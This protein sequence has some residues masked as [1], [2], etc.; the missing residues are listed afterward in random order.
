[1]PMY[2]YDCHDCNIRYEYHVPL[3]M[4][5]DEIRCKKCDLVLVKVF[6]APAI[7]VH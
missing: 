3:K 6:S 4:M 1:M 5:N 7:Y 2:F